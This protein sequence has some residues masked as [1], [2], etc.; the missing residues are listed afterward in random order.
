MVSEFDGKRRKNVVA[1]NPTSA[2]LAVVT[3]TTVTKRKLFYNVLLLRF[4][5]GAGFGS[6]SGDD[7]NY[8]M[9]RDREKDRRLC[10]DSFKSSLLHSEQL[11]RRSKRTLV[12]LIT[13]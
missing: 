11:F 6:S 7:H 3:R 13:V 5:L 4:F 12:I 10:F 2:R 1:V 8:E 9:E